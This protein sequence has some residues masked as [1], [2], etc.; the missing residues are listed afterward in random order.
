MADIEILPNC[1][2]NAEAA[3]QDSLNRTTKD[4]PYLAIWY[5]DNEYKWS[6]ANL[7]YKTLMGFIGIL[8][9]LAQELAQNFVNGEKN[10]E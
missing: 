10:G 5:L 1:N 9:C 7:D 4:S 3:A 8:T 6:I 2:W